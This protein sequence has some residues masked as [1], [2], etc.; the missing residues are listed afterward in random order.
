MVVK[1]QAD[2]E[3]AALADPPGQR[4]EVPDNVAR[5]TVLLV[6]TK[7]DPLIVRRRRPLGF[8]HP[9]AE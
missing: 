5:D 8:R 6:D 7:G 1:P 3:A 2:R 9:G 4:R